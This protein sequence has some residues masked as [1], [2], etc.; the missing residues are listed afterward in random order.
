MLSRRLY[1]SF[2]SLRGAKLCPF[3]VTALHI[4]VKKQ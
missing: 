1:Q 3:S 4:A 2:L